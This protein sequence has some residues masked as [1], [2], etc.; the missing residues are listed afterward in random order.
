MGAPQCRA[1]PL[2][3]ELARGELP[4]RLPGLTGALERAAM[5]CEHAA[6]DGCGALLRLGVAAAEADEPVGAVVAGG[7]RAQCAP[8][9]RRLQLAESS[10]HS[11]SVGVLRAVGSVEVCIGGGDGLAV[12]LD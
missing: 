3:F 5:A 4:C 7:Q 1:D 10:S 9:S 2:D 12:G 6:E 8:M 11:L